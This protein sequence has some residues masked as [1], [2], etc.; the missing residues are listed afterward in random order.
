MAGGIASGGHNY[1][2]ATSENVHSKIIAY[3]HQAIVEGVEYKVMS[4][5]QSLSTIK[6]PFVKNKRK[7]TVLFLG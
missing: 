1:S 6:A 5:I 4:V 7:E 2:V 3:E